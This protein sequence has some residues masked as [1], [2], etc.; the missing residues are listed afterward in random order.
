MATRTLLVLLVLK[1]VAAAV[2]IGSG[3]RGGLF[4]ASLLLGALLGKLF[5]T[6]VGV[7]SPPEP[8]SML[9]AIV[10]MSAFGA[11]VIGA[12]LAMTFLALETTRDFAVAGPV[13]IGVTI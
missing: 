10:G 8:D 5:S 13:L 7:L 3:F 11:A 2:S 1:T 4:F 9:L 12:P 6:L